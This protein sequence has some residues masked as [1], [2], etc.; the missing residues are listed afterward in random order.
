MGI[1][2]VQDVEDGSIGWWI[3]DCNFDSPGSL[4]T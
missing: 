3:T 2:I 4:M 1:R